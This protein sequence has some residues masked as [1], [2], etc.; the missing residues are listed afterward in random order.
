MILKN[1]LDFL[2]KRAASF[3]HAHSQ[4]RHKL[5]RSQIHCTVARKKKCNEWKSAK[6]QTPERESRY[7]LVTKAARCHSS[8]LFRLFIAIVW[9]TGSGTMAVH[10][11]NKEST[12]RDQVS[13][14]VARCIALVTSFAGV[15]S[16][17]ET[18]PRWLQGET[19]EVGFDVCTRNTK[20]PR[21]AVIAR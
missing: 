7:V 21:I 12:R 10:E 13:P 11:W 19:S 3:T 6:I 4:S 16:D 1:H 20:R 15:G 18:P 8:W 14:G 2:E 17:K 5:H 9:R